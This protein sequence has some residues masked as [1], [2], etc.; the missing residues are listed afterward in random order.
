MI[1]RSSSTRLDLV[2]V[3][4]TEV[5]TTGVKRTLAAAVANNYSNNFC[6]G[7]TAGRRHI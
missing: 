2:V 7:Y 1:G 5:M 3:M 4:E 6:S